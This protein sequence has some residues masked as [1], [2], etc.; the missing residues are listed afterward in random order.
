[1][2]DRILVVDDDSSMRE[3][4]SQILSPDY[5]I[6]CVESGYRAMVEVR[7]NHYDLV[8]L[9]IMMPGLD[10]ISTID[11]LRELQPD[12]PIIIITGL[13]DEGINEKAIEK[14]AFCVMNKPFVQIDIINAVQK[15]L[16]ENAANC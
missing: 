1:M 3:M 4:V 7:N 11:H 9:D 13:G 6:Q 2:A 5:D 12:L 16:S 8:L 14:G 10:G 15:A